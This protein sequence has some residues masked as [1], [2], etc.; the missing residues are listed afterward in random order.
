MGLMTKSEYNRVKNGEHPRGV[1]CVIQIVR[2]NNSNDGNNGLWSSDAR[3]IFSRS[4]KN[5]N[6][7]YRLTKAYY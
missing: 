7:F 6:R 5:F 1:M 4:P 2:I 3:D